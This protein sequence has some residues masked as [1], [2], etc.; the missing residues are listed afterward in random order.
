MFRASHIKTG[1]RVE[2]T[3][4]SLMVLRCSIPGP[5]LR[6]AGILFVW[7]WPPLRVPAGT[8]LRPSSFFSFLIFHGFRLFGNVRIWADFWMVVFDFLLLTVRLLKVSTPCCD[9]VLVHFLIFA[10]VTFCHTIAFCCDF[11]YMRD[12]HD[13]GIGELSELRKCSDSKDPLIQGAG[14]T[15][16]EGDRLPAPCRNLYPTGTVA[17]RCFAGHSHPIRNR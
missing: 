7:A 10:G 16:K 4:G 9:C 3:S 5:R 11:L 17:D 6:F 2:R 1:K 8:E 12:I 13:V 14:K 15:R